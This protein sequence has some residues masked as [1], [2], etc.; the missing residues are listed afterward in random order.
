MD[1]L[2]QAMK[3]VLFGAAAVAALVLWLT[4]DRFATSS[5]QRPAQIQ[6]F[7]DEDFSGAYKWVD[8]SSLAVASPLPGA[9][10]C[11]TQFPDGSA[12]YVSCQAFVTVGGHYEPQR[13]NSTS[14]DIET[15]FKT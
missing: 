5:N 13:R 4:L 2:V 1:R 11:D 7:T 9:T 6:V 3:A 15:L 14:A 8:A 12:G 10:A